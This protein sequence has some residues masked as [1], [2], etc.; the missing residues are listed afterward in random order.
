[1]EAIELN[2]D[3]LDVAGLVTLADVELELARKPQP[4][5]RHR[6][7]TTLQF[8]GETL[9]IGDGFLREFGVTSEQ[10]KASFFSAQLDFGASLIDVPLLPADEFVGWLEIVKPDTRFSGGE[11]KGLLNFRLMAKFDQEDLLPIL[12]SG[13]NALRISPWMLSTGKYFG[14]RADTS[15]LIYV[16][17]VKIARNFQD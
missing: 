6:S 1:M 10:A 2:G 13:G 5:N 16:R 9:S 17:S 14:Y 4:N 11:A 15:M 8:Y 7:G 3:K 12:W